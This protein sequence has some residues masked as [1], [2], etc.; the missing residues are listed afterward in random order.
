[1]YQVVVEEESGRKLKR[2]LGMQECFPV[3]TSHGEAQA[4]GAP[5]YCTAELPPSSLPET[6]PFTVGDNHT[7]NGYW[8]SPLDPRKNYLIYFQAM[9][10]FRGVSEQLLYFEFSIKRFALINFK[11]NSEK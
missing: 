4:R 3:P 10:N 11:I 6:T 9:S 7:Y 2:E 1:T 5:H 8:N